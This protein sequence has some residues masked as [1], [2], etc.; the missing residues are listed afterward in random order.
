MVVNLPRG[1][2]LS[3]RRLQRYRAGINSLQPHHHSRP[4]FRRLIPGPGRDPRYAQHRRVE[5]FAQFIVGQVGQI[6]QGL[7]D[8]EH[9][10]E[11]QSLG[12]GGV[13]AEYQGEGRQDLAGVDPMAAPVG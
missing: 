8:E 7:G 3:R 10:V 9:G 1:R 2:G 12:A 5:G 6:G 13:V 11:G 4:V